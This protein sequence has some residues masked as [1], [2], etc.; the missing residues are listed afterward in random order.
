MRPLGS[1]IL[2]N[3]ARSCSLSTEED[4]TVLLLSESDCTLT[5]TQDWVNKRLMKEFAEAFKAPS[6]VGN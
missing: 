5:T 3:S 2:F 4:K 1:E 6:V